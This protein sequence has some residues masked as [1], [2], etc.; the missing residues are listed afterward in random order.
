[1][2]RV[3]NKFKVVSILFTSSGNKKVILSP[4]Y[5]GQPEYTT[6]TEVYDNSER[7]LE[8]L[9]HKDNTYFAMNALYNMDL[10]TV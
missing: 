9:V 8:I 3:T 5:V 4:I 6:N 2:A 1:M 10:T 7:I